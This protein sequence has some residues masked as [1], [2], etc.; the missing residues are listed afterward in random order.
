MRSSPSLND[1]W[2]ACTPIALK[3]YHS[4][5]DAGGTKDE[6]ISD[7]SGKDWKDFEDGTM[8]GL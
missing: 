1:L 5:V 8:R 4:D 3:I 7:G 2:H 6:V